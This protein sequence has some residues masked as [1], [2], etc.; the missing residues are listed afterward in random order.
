M[1]ICYLRPTLQLPSPFLLTFL[2]EHQ[3]SPAIHIRQ[4]I[5]TAIL[6]IAKYFP[7]HI[8]RPFPVLSQLN[9]SH[10]KVALMQFSK[11]MLLFYLTCLLISGLFPIVLVPYNDQY[12]QTQLTQNSYAEPSMTCQISL[13]C[14][15]SVAQTCVC[16]TPIKLQNNWS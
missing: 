13:F 16:A 6:K 4:L 2:L 8:Q 11:Y 1:L 3:L 7:V 5:K 10:S 15:P 9:P 14:A 12:F